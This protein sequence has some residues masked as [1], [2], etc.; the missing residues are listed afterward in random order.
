M[1]QVFVGAINAPAGL[2]LSHD[3]A[4]EICPDGKNRVEA[5]GDGGGVIVDGNDAIIRIGIKQTL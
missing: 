5:A 3:I 1:E 2:G 4:I